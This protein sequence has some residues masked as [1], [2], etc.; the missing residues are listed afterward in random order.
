VIAAGDPFYVLTQSGMKG[1]TPSQI[2]GELSETNDEDAES[3][4]FGY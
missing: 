2:S 3:A 1:V 4:K